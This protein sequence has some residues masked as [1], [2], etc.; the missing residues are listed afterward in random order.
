MRELILFSLT[1]ML[2]SC[3]TGTKEQ[4]KATTDDDSGPAWALE[5]VW[6]S[7]TLLS[8]C[9]SVLYDEA[10][11]Q[12]IVS[13]INGAPWEKDGQGFIALVNL[14]GSLKSSPWIE[15]LNA[16]KGSGLYDGLLY[17]ADMNQVVVIDMATA[18]IREKITLDGAE[19]L[20]DISIDEDGTVYI[21]DS[22]TGWVWTLKDGEATPW[23]KEGFERPNGLLVEKDRVLLA[24]SGSS[25]FY[26]IDK[27]SGSF[28][29]LTEEIGHGDGIAS[30]GKEGHYIVSNWS[31]EVF[32][33]LPDFSKIQLLDTREDEINAADIGFNVAG[34]V[35]YVPT[36]FDNRVVAYRLVDQSAR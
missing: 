28:E 33:V 3:G 31:G 25:L 23:L 34:Q 36:F 12:L 15:G 22:Q 10:G 27:A 4:S 20:N 24:T 2:V 29:I 17:V 19:Q 5:Q 32:L 16:P 8:T 35:L 26:E 1:M 18:G 6:E 9:E 11:R 7:D 14:D 21:S 13:C 30:T